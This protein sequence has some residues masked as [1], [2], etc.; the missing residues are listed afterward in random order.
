MLTRPP[1][2]ASAAA[3]LAR[4]LTCRGYAKRRADAAGAREL[5]KQRAAFCLAQKR[6]VMCAYA[7]FTPLV[8][9]ICGHAV[10]I[11]FGTAV[12]GL[13]TPHRLV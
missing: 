1:E 6:R 5:D 12:L 10:R 3:L 4:C 13:E 8:S 7:Y 2:P 9:P 11:M